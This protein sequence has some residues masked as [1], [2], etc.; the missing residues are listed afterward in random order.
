MKL[1]KFKIRNKTVEASFLPCQGHISES[2]VNV[3]GLLILGT[4]DDN[5]EEEL[6]RKW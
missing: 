4:T 1:P 5:G 3:M 6:G 2:E